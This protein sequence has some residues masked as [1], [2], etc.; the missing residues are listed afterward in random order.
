LRGQAAVTKK[1]EPLRDWCAGTSSS[2]SLEAPSLLVHG[3]EDLELFL[4]LELLVLLDLPRLGGILLTTIGAAG[5]AG[6]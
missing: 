4:L 1:A 6:L 2:S 5:W 3:S